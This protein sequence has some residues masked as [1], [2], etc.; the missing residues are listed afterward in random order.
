MIFVEWRSYT[1]KARMLSNMRGLL[2]RCHPL[3]PPPPPPAAAADVPPQRDDQ[4]ALARLRWRLAAAETLLRTVRRPSAPLPPPGPPPPSHSS[5]PP[6]SSS[7][8]PVEP[9]QERLLPPAAVAHA[10]E[11]EHLR[12]RVAMIEASMQPLLAEL[13]DRRELL[14]HAY[15]LCHRAIVARDAAIA[16]SMVPPAH[17]QFATASVEAVT[18]WAR[19]GA[20]P[21]TAPGAPPPPRPSVDEAMERV[22]E[23]ALR[24]NRRLELQL[25]QANE[26]LEREGKPMATSEAEGAGSSRINW[27]PP[28]R[29][30]QPP[31]SA[32]PTPV[33]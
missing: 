6:R 32:L 20:P 11:N 15:V 7:P 3:A 19:S 28:S 31:R 1:D 24:L 16:H 12:E 13:S 29:Q 18:A 17:A 23:D 33:S 2:P 5:P 9:R 22:L 26:K 25:T 30:E 10:E 8:P 4:P 27:R 21:P 14:H